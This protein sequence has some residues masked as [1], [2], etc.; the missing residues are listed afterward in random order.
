M[1]RL[2]RIQNMQPAESLQPLI[3]AL[4]SVAGTPTEFKIDP[5]REVFI[6]IHDNAPMISIGKQPIAESD[7]PSDTVLATARSAA[8]LQ[9]QLDGMRAEN[10]QL[11]VDKDAPFN[12]IPTKGR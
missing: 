2:V 7:L 4:H 5:Q 1:T 11:R 10:Q 8:G 6:A 9:E 3:A 12:Q